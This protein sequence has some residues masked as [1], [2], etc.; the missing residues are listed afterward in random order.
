MSKEFGRPLSK[1]RVDRRKLYKELAQLLNQEPYGH[2]IV[3]TEE[4]V[5][6]LGCGRFFKDEWALEV[7]LREYGTRWA[8]RRVVYICQ[9]CL[10]PYL[11]PRRLVV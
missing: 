9:E 11:I 10:K 3:F 8:K 2:K 6:C 1:F 4:V 7:K 5:T